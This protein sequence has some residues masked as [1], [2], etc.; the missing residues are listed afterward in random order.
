MIDQENQKPRYQKKP[1]QIFQ[2]VHKNSTFLIIFSFI[3]FDIISHIHINF[4]QDYQYK[5]NT[6]LIIKEEHM[7]I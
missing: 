6:K 2:F 7:Y 4:Y 1:D 3:Y 5:I